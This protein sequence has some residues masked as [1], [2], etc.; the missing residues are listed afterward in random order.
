M[1]KPFEIFQRK[2][3]GQTAQPNHPHPWQHGGLDTPVDTAHHV[4]ATKKMAWDKHMACMFTEKSGFS[5][6]PRCTQIQCQISFETTW[7]PSSLSLLF[8]KQKETDSD[9]VY[10]GSHK[11]MTDVGMVPN[12]NMH[13]SSW[14]WFTNINKM[15]DGD[16]NFTWHHRARGLVF[17]VDTHKW[18]LPHFRHVILRESAGTSSSPS[19]SEFRHP[20]S[21][22]P[23]LPFCKVA[24]K[25]Q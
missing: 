16:I 17:S 1:D 4:S 19:S 3:T 23:L 2:R 5:T 9:H 22:D 25:T 11:E 14:S 6:K 20:H 24:C 13:T 12:H 8:L 15:H 18:L 7:L 10:Q 21:G